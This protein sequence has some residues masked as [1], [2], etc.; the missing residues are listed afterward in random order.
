M[1]PPFAHRRCAIRLHC[2]VILVPGAFLAK[3]I[4]FPLLFAC[5]EETIFSSHSK[6]SPLQWAIVQGDSFS[7][8]CEKDMGNSTAD[9]DLRQHVA[10][11]VAEEVAPLLDMDGGGI[12]VVAVEQ[13]VVQVRLHG[14]CGCC[15]GS[16]Q[17]VILGIEEEL[18][19]RVPEVEYL[20][21]LL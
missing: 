18:R 8:R 12:E 6:S 21:V 11:V 7:F 16:V 15:P 13:G 17:A 19:R 1:V 10:R 2:R 14:A 9:D 4:A 20:E 5:S 3:E